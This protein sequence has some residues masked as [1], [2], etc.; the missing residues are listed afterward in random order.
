MLTG[1][2]NLFLSSAL[3][4]TIYCKSNEGAN[5][6]TSRERQGS[7]PV[8]GSGA[9]TAPSARAQNAGS[10][11]RTRGDPDP[12]QH[13]PAQNLSG[14]VSQLT[15]CICTMHVHPP[16]LLMLLLWVT[17][18]LCCCRESSRCGWM[19]SPKASASLVLR[20]TSHHASLRSECCAA[21]RSE[22]IPED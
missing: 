19:C 15:H 9:R 3:T 1:L 7:P 2:V 10:R 20:L 18:M 14:S 8:L 16:T 4:G 21:L 22:Q 17:R 5:L 12:L 6:I 11:P 13:L